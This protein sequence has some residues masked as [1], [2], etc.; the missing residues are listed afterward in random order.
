MNIYIEFIKQVSLIS[1]DDHQRK[2]LIKILSHIS[3]REIL[4]SN[5]E[6]HHI[7]PQSW[8]NN[9]AN[10][11]DNIIRVTC[12]EHFIIHRLMT[13]AFPNDRPMAVSYWLLSKGRILN[14]REYERVKGMVADGMKER[15][16]G[17]PSWNS[18]LTLSDKHRQRMSESKKGKP[19]SEKR[20]EASKQV[21][22]RKPPALTEEQRAQ[23]SRRMIEDN[24]AK[25]L[26]V[27]QKM[28]EKARRPKSDKWK[29]S[30]RGRQ[31]PM[32]GKQQ[33]EEQ[34]K[35][36]GDMKRGKIWITN[37]IISKMIS[38]EEFIFYQNV[39]FYLGRGKCMR[40]IKKCL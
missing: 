19:W 14:A 26:E 10:E 6:K 40:S 32:K 9:D 38:K 2:R 22:K 34:K 13:K 5:Y 1:V 8:S 35:K 39:G 18:G 28:S 11:N 24:P 27:R 23:I 33:S 17:R 37:G 21:T 29:E 16:R 15:R 4:N 3:E 36:N 25:R 30:V 12:K 20:R 7:V 31:S